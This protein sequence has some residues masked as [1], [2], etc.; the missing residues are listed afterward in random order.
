MK[1]VSFYFLCWVVFFFLCLSVCPVSAQAPTRPKIIFNS[2]RDNGNAEI[3]MMNT[4]G[5]QEVR[6]T[7]HP[8][9]DFQPVWS[10]T[11][12]QILFVSDRDGWRDLY[13]M[14][15]DGAN[16]RRVFKKVVIR[17]QPAWSPDGAQIAYLGNRGDDWAIYIAT[18]E[19]EEERLA[20]SGRTG[21]F[22][23][24]SPDGTE[25]VFAVADFIGIAP[26]SLV[27]YN[28]HTGKEETFH[29]QPQLRMFYPSWAPD[30][31]IAFSHVEKLGGKGP[32]I[33]TLYGVNRDGGDLNE[34]VPEKEPIAVDAT[35]SPLGDEL[36][37]HRQVGEN[38]QIFKINLASQQ[39]QQLTR[40]GINVY[41]D[42]FDPA[43]ALPVS[44]KPR[45]LTT[46]W[47]KVKISN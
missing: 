10:P 9:A 44:P 24:W 4:D 12:E 46:V 14:D 45:L 34:L 19:G 29:P 28:L 1:Y 26:S 40:R 13:L 41:P 8:D 16:V 37:Y 20:W 31:T 33:G 39:S 21:G 18:L 23:A 32:V 43:F 38:R 5:S 22:P 17:Q 11:G 36:A 42:W 47:A 7:R 2:N 35:W 6:L 25:I 15:A 27:I 3:Y 30:N